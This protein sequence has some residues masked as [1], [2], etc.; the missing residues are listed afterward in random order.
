MGMYY[1]SPKEPDYG[2]AATESAQAQANLLPLQLQTQLDYQPLFD[3]L[4][5]AQQERELTSMLN[6]LTGTQEEPNLLRAFTQLAGLEDEYQGY[7][8]GLGDRPDRPDRDAFYFKPD[9]GSWGIGDW[10]DQQLTS[11]WDPA[12][13]TERNADAAIFDPMGLGDPF[14]I[15]EKNEQ[16]E[17]FDPE[18]YAA[19]MA[20]YEA[21][22]KEWNAQ[23]GQKSREDW[24]LEYIDAN[25]ESSAANWYAKELERE[26]PG[27]LDELYKMDLEYLPKSAEA[28][29]AAQ[30]SIQEQYGDLFLDKALEQARR[31]D[32]DWFATREALAKQIETD[33]AAG[34]ELTDQERRLVE[35]QIRRSQADRGNLYGAQPSADEV[36]SEFLASNQ[37]KQQ[38]YQ[39]AAAFIAGQQPSSQMAGVQT[40][41]GGAA[42]YNPTAAGT[43]GQIAMPGFNAA[44]SVWNAGAVDQGTNSIYG[45]QQQNYLSN[46]QAKHSFWS[47]LAGSGMGMASS[48]MMMCWVAAEIY[49][50]D[51]PQWWAWREWL[52][53]GPLSLFEAYRKHGQ[54]YAAE[55]GNDPE[56]KARVK[57]IMDAV[58]AGER[59]E[60]DELAWFEGDLKATRPTQVH[61]EGT[62][63]TEGVEEAL[64]RVPR[65]QSE[66]LLN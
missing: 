22:V 48:A 19:A 61:H 11:P 55:L 33:L 12:G 60:A 50:K 37:K 2:A 21:R 3:E 31:A 30:L 39:N 28:N 62:K 44:Q 10:I 43:S 46:Q 47:D 17:V 15:V 52:F 5:F 7:V 45:F 64:R 18:K 42:P 14:G 25:P 41:Q 4:A 36:L 54:A 65:G 16:G 58:V 24:L 9:D 63:G 23:G 29:A 49:G 51:T 26:T 53:K 20:E 1:D 38:N 8:D 59:P 13:F 32:P 34:G 57:A 6:F 35:Q 66:L 56:R 27:L 40:A